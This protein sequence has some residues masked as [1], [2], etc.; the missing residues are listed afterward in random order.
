MKRIQFLALVLMGA[1]FLVG[2]VN[3]NSSDA[4]PES[5]YSDSYRGSVFK[6]P[7]LVGTTI[8][9]YELD[10]QLAQ[11]GTVYEGDI[12]DNSGEYSVPANIS[13]GPIEVVAS[14]YYFD[15]VTGQTSSDILTLRAISVGQN[16]VNLSVVSALEQDRVRTLVQ[17]GASIAGAKEQ[18][19]KDI[20]AMIDYTP[21]SQDS[22]EVTID[23]AD[24]A[25]LLTLT[26]ILLSDTNGGARSA[27]EIQ[28]MV[29]SLRVDMA[30][31]LI[32]SSN[33]ERLYRSA[34]WTNPNVIRSNLENRFRSVGSTIS[35]PE[36][37]SDVNRFLDTNPKHRVVYHQGSP[38]G[39]IV[40]DDTFYDAGQTTSVIS[41]TF[42]RT[43]S[44]RIFIGW[45]STQ[46]G[47]GESFYTGDSISVEAGGTELF[48]QW[49]N[50][51]PGYLYMLG[52]NGEP[53]FIEYWDYEGRYKTEWRSDGYD[54]LTTAA[55]YFGGDGTSGDMDSW[56]RQ[57]IRA[58]DLS[59]PTHYPDH[60]KHVGGLPSAQ[61]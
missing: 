27:P 8:R 57:R 6:G 53:K 3:P 42:A 12:I 24:G 10:D 39:Q 17:Q 38:N 33:S 1:T 58:Y 61:Q 20:F 44:D 21:V 45:N 54:V 30:D 40:V 43:Q 59:I 13:E 2:C 52:P 31:G 55:E 29:T 14:G 22:A 37:S 7:Y 41:G 11:T 60:T 16:V 34:A 32:G 18:A 4:A 19:L 36:F 26:S 9:V 25:A 28:T 51:G 35:V 50:Y 49:G 56:Y 46:D 48:G 5:K 15:E 23:S 47:T